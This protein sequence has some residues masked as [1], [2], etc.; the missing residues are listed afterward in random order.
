MPVTQ[1]SCALLSA[2]V[3]RNGIEASESSVRRIL[4]RAALVLPRFRGQSHYAAR[5]VT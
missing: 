5:A 4:R 3:L 2:Q 1:W